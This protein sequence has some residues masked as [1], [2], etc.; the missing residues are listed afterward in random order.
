MVLVILLYISPLNCVGQYVHIN[1]GLE[2]PEVPEK[3]LVSIQILEW[4]SQGIL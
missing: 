3:I 2:T 1:I 4:S